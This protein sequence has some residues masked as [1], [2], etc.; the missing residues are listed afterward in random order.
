VRAKTYYIAPASPLTETPMAERLVQHKHCP[1]CGK[2][3]STE[4]E[5]C[6]DECSVRREAQIRERKRTMY[7]FYF[8]MAIMV[9]VLVL[10]FTGG[11]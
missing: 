11:I 1:V 3:M 10:Q 9:V 7:I 8:A 2:A 5:T 6:S 4:K